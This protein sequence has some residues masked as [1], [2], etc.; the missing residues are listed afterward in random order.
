MPDYNTIEFTGLQV[1][2]THFCRIPDLAD[3][4]IPIFLI[5]TCPAICLR[6]CFHHTHAGIAAIASEIGKGRRRASSP[7][8]AAS[9]WADGIY[10][11]S[12]RSIP[13]SKTRKKSPL[14]TWKGEKGE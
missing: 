9:I 13:A 4:G 7:N 1:F 11:L 8:S 14:H 6:I 12:L 10:T 3:W 5:Y 2:E